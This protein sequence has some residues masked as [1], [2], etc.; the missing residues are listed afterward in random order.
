[1]SISDI[2][3]SE[4]TK[5]MPLVSLGQLDAISMHV[6]MINMTQQV[7]VHNIETRVSREISIDQKLVCKNHFKLPS[8]ADWRVLLMACMNEIE[9]RLWFAIEDYV[10]FQSKHL[11]STKFYVAIPIPRELPQLLPGRQPTNGEAWPESLKLKNLPM[12]GKRYLINNLR[13]IKLRTFV[14]PHSKRKLARRL[15]QI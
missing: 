5:V 7:S 6:E 9:E 15:C 13:Q 12:S 11:P 10:K 1:V 3:G 14:G 8:A 4:L 2:I